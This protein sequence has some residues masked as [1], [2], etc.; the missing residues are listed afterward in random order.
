M[1]PFSMKICLLED[2][3]ERAFEDAIK[4]TNVKSKLIIFVN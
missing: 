1:C 2:A 3:V 4:S